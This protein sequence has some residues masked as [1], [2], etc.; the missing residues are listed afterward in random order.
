VFI[1]I[2]GVVLH[3]GKPFEWSK[4]AIHAL[5]NNDIPFVFVTNGT[6]CSAVLVDNLTKILEL[7]FT[8][9]HVVVAPSPCCAL[10]EYHDKRVLVCCQEDSHGLVPE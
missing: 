5:W 6:Y 3:G 4:E 1:D 9:E 7:P 8:N 2:D 10:T